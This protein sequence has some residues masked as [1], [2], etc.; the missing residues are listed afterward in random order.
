MGLFST[1]WTTIQSVSAGFVKTAE[2][3]SLSDGYTQ[4]QYR[5]FMC[6]ETYLYSA[7]YCSKRVEI[8]GGAHL[9]HAAQ[10][11]PVLVVFLHHGSWLLMNGAIHHQLGLAVTSIASRRNLDFCTQE[12][13]EFWLGVHQRAAESCRAPVVFY[14]DQ[15]PR[16]SIRWLSRPGQVLTVAMDVREPR[17]ERPEYP[18]HFLGETIYLQ[19]GPARLA[20]LT[21]AQIV[22]AAIEY[23]PSQCRH[24]LTLYPAI[25][26]QCGEHAATQ[27]ALDSL[28]PRIA[29]VPAQQFYDLVSTLKAP[30]RPDSQ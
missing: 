19:T 4:P 21:G 11:G 8:V 9:T 20:K 17:F 18:F 25:D 29:A 12:E 14:T 10:K 1:V 24:R 7:A 5:A 27:Q 16:G 3:P 23:S 15:N 28:A 2:P 13:R 22:P 26:P 30:Q 6:A